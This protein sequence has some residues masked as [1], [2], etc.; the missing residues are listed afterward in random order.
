MNS[1]DLTLQ[2]YSD[3]ESL[4]PWRSQWDELTQDN[5]ML[6]FVWQ[7][8]W[9]NAFADSKRGDRK[10]LAVA[11]LFDSQEN[12]AGIVPCYIATTT[13]ARVLRFLGD[14]KVASDYLRLL[15][16]EGCE[17]R[18][19][20]RMV[21][22]IQSADF[23]QQFGPLDRIECEG[24]RGSEPTIELLWA[25]LSAN[26]WTEHAVGIEGSW[27]IEFPSDWPALRKL[28]CKSY[29]RKSNKAQR[30][31][32]NGSIEF[33]WMT[34]PDQIVESWPDFVRLHQK[35]RSA[36]GQLGCFTEPQFELFL[37]QAVLELSESGKAVLGLI[38][39]QQ[40]PIAATLLLL[41][42]DCAMMYQ[43]GIDPD[44]SH[45]EP[46]HLVNNFSLEWTM[47]LGKSSFD[48]LRGDE[49]Y[50]RGWGAHRTEL[51]RTRMIA[52]RWISQLK[53][54]LW[55]T[56]RRAKA[57]VVDASLSNPKPRTISKIEEPK[58]C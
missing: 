18:V 53:H 52:P 50:K 47:Q 27:R 26:G 48:F 31:L 19:A 39:H 7:S 17:E 3:F 9:W 42:A 10:Q 25:K 28:F 54:S 2:T 56:A 58:S 49:S 15:S 30:M 4:L 1:Q 57:M 51:Y 6:G 22:W 23:Q 14:G 45:L 8:N 34:T 35:R 13:T 36:L 33:N 44:C 24:H 32:E 21:E 41:S 20:T 40:K 43:S 5:P 37:S 16:R 38:H 29:Q 12:V 55:L 11:V 46:G